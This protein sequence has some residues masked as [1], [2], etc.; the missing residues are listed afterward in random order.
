MSI[1]QQESTT[2]NQPFIVSKV[3]D[4]AIMMKPNLSFMIAFSSIIG[5]LMGPGV[6]F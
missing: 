6:F 1:L 4:Y 2:R 5:Y 3:R